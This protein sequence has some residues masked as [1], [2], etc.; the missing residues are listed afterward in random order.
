LAYFAKSKIIDWIKKSDA[1]LKEINIS[2]TDNL[3]NYGSDAPISDITF[4]FTITPQKLSSETLLAFPPDPQ[5]VKDYQNYFD[6]ATNI[7]LNNYKTF[8]DDAVIAKLFS[9]KRKN[10]K[11]LSKEKYLYWFYY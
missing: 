11:L 1:S 7:I 6:T 3:M 8:D 2:Y 5:N 10:P 4:N 9:F